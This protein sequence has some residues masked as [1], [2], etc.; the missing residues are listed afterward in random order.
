MT[1]DKYK[2]LI[3]K[4]FGELTVVDVKL[5]Q[6]YYPNGAKNGLDVEYVCKC[7]CGKTTLV[8]RYRL[9]EGKTK[10]CGCLRKELSKKRK[11]THGLCYTR[12]NRI[13]HKIKS[14]CLSKTSDK[15]K[16][17]GERGIKICK[18]W[19]KEFMKFY[20]WSINNGYKDNLTIDRIDVNGDY[21]P[22]N[23][24]W[25]TQAE[26]MKNTRRN[27]NYNGRC[28]SDWGRYFKIPY[29]KFYSLVS[30]E[31]L[32]VVVDKLLKEQEV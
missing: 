31:G 10:S 32:D 9:L 5:K 24:R 13:Y 7:E 15:Y 25:I 20:E 30:K 8:K 3:G 14:R 16:W 26:Q 28:L 17:Y 4:K 6:L 18:E 11:T 19:E 27:R 2:E 12:L 22:S 1:L 23:C 29:N 21:E